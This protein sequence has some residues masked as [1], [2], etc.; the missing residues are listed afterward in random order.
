MIR[1]FRGC[2]LVVLLF[3]F[4]RTGDLA[5]VLWLLFLVVTAVRR[6]PLR[7]CVSIR[8]GASDQSAWLR[9]VNHS[10]RHTLSTF[11][12]CFFFAAAGGLLC[13]GS[14]LPLLSLLESGFFQHLGPLSCLLGIDGLILGYGFLNGFDL[15]S[16]PFRTV[17][18]PVKEVHLVTLEKLGLTGV[19]Q[20]TPPV[21]TMPLM[22]KP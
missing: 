7:G 14:G 13:A 12:S 10:H 20:L 16:L 5:V 19:E 3:S 1:I 17:G 2:F 8:P 22:A 6:L 4:F 21:L 9:F 11:G 15:C 18:I